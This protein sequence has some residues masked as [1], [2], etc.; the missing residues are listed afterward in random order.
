MLFTMLL[1]TLSVVITIAVL[2]VN[3]RSPVTHKLAP[4]VRACF[5][6]FL[7]KFLFIQRPKKEED[8]KNP[9]NMLTDV[10]PIPL[11]DKCKTYEKTSFDSFDLGR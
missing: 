6:D 11:M 4:W 9:D 3:F 1:C 8:D 5:I 2:N 7:P 10:I